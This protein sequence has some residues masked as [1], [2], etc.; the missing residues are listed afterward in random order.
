MKIR[1][2]RVDD[3]GVHRVSQRHIEEAFLERRQWSPPGDYSS[4]RIVSLICDRRLLPVEGYFLRA[5]VEQGHIS[6]E[7]RYRLVAFFQSMAASR[8]KLGPI[9]TRLIREQRLGWPKAAALLP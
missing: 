2:F 3:G 8:L 9:E 6:D 5:E 7:S 4:L 1:Y